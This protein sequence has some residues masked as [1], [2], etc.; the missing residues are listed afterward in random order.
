MIP[1]AP[2][3]GLRRPWEELPEFVLALAILVSV[4][5]VAWFF[6]HFGYLPQP[7]LYDTNDTF[8][9]WYNTSYWA[10]NGGAYN[11]WQS[12]YPPLSFVFLR[13]FSIHSCY[14]TSPFL[15]RDCD[16][17]GRLVLGVFYGLNVFLVACCYWKTDRRTALPRTLAMSIGLP[18]LFALERGNLIIPC[19]TAFALGHGPL[20]RKGWLRQL[21]VALTINFKPYLLLATF[22]F[23][24]ET[25]WRM[26]FGCGVATILVYCFTYAFV[27]AGGFTEL[28]ANTIN[29]TSFTGAQF[30]NEVYYSTSYASLLSFLNS[31]FPILNYVGSDTVEIPRLVLPLVIHAGQ[32]AVGLCFLGAWLNPGVV[33]TDRLVALSLAAA[34]TTSS[35]G[36]YAEVFLLF[37]VFMEPWKGPG[38]I[39]ALVAAY[40]LCLSADYII[41][42]IRSGDT[43]SWLGARTVYSV[44][45][46][47]AGQFLRPALILALEFGLVGATLSAIAKAAWPNRGRLL[48]L[49]DY[50]AI[51]SEGDARSGDTT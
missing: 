20:L 50:L 10:N 48:W 47:S 19:F 41:L 2:Y 22:P 49:A 34:M 18:M 16:W 6:I 30:W 5:D 26:L 40:L 12:V 37:V 31:Q 8:M 24:I 35:P 7:Y 27:Q 36:G 1:Q 11:I 23:A 38:T 44:F 32:L 33:T 51:Q 28:Y 21:N 46:V 13:A 25:R 14:G 4:C 39:T 45:G 17:L 43:F 15:A 3:A 42:P 9:D 29:W